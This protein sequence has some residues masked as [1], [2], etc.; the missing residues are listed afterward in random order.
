MI[1]VKG[2]TK[3][4][5]DAQQRTDFK[6]DNTSNVSAADKEKF[7]GGEDIGDTLNKVADPNFVNES[8]K[9]RTHG[10]NQLGK[11]AFMTLLLT[12]MKNQDPTNPLKSHE[13][14]AQLAQFTSLEK[15]QGIND[16]IEGLRK[17]AQPNQNFDALAF[18]GKA[19]TTDNSKIARVEADARHDI[20]FT[21][22]SDAQKFSMQ[23]KDAA[24]NVIRT[25]E[26]KAI[27]AGK[28][29][30]NWNGLTDEGSPAPIGDYTVSFEAVASNGRKLHVETKTEGIISGVNFTPKGPQLMVGK[31]VISMSD[32]KTISDPSAQQPNM[33]TPKM[34]I[35]QL[36]PQFEG[37]KKVEVKPQT[38]T[39]GAK[40]ARLSQGSLEGA[41]MEQG[42]INK[43][44][45]EGA[46]AGGM[47]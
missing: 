18:I 20:G 15:L 36:L 28:Q 35:D 45:K 43:L 37:P 23:I 1:G 31:Q 34:P 10:N 30:M 12:Q 14:A 5:S 3:T 27:K 4:W 40:R 26:S 39:D 22:P 42:L 17:D 6:S 16:G 47:G 8:K 44:N 9:M 32:V 46:K 25:L 29:E 11:D 41:A 2:G 13:M 19:V 21:L 38:Q 33:N 24:G 7:F